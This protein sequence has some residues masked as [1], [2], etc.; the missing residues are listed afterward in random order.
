MTSSAWLS[1]W[2]ALAGSIFAQCRAINLIV[3]QLCCYAVMK[4]V[5]LEIIFSASVSSRDSSFLDNLCPQFM[6]PYF[7]NLWGHT[8]SVFWASDCWWG[9]SRWGCVLISSRR[10]ERCLGPS[11]LQCC[12]LNIRSFPRL[13]TYAA[14]VSSSYAGWTVLA[15]ID[16]L[17]CNSVPTLNDVPKPTWRNHFYH[18]EHPCSAVKLNRNALILFHNLLAYPLVWYDS[19]FTLL[20]ISPS[21]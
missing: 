17:I 11:C 15:F 14:R 1:C 9:Y 4:A 10:L 7:H 13:H 3:R 20:N 5:M 19:L 21:S 12:S 8:M 6:G 18:T 16:T 2:P